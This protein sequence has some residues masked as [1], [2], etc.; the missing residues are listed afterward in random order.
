MLVG[1]GVTFR[2][3]AA[4]RGARTRAGGG[5]VRRA[6]A[7]DPFSAPC[8][9]PRELR[10]QSNVVGIIAVAETATGD[11]ARR[12][13]NVVTSMSGRTIEIRR[14]SSGEARLLLCDALT[15]AERFEPDC[16]IDVGTLTGSSSSPSARTRAASSPTTTNWR[17]SLCRCGGESGDRVW[18]LPLWDDYLAARKP[19][20]RRCQP[21]GMRRRSDLGRLLPRPASPR[22]F[23][24]RISTSPERHRS[25]AAAKASTGRPVPLLTNSSFGRA[26]AA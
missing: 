7:P 10:L 21:D 18:R 22:P 17:R 12:P 20:C 9:R 19:A 5:A 6:A 15:Y 1:Q 3:A 2:A 14:P 24:G 23:P 25:R 26:R 8:G 13:G 11:G 4:C 16:V